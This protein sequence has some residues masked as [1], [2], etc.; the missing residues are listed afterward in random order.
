[1]EQICDICGK[2]F[3]STTELLQHKDKVHRNEKSQR[4]VEEECK[5]ADPLAQ[6]KRD[7][8]EEQ[9][10]LGKKNIGGI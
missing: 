9:S 2:L 10:V 5:S 3:Y 4:Y 8:P 7:I 6:P 1:M